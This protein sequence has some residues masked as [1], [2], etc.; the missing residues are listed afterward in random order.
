MKNKRIYKVMKL[1]KA[2]W[3]GNKYTTIDDLGKKWFFTFSTI[4]EAQKI[5]DKYN[6]TYC[7]SDYSN[8][9]ILDYFNSI[10][11][12]PLLD[13]INSLIGL[14]LTYDINI[15]KDSQGIYNYFE[16][17]NKENLVDNFPIL[18]LAWREFKVATF[19]SSILCDEATGKLSLWCTINY[20][21]QHH[22]FGGNGVE[23]LTVWYEEGKWIIKTDKETFNN[24]D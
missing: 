23:I 9:E 16:I 2:D 21:Y 8:D 13:K 5:C 10:D 14:E 11:F 1:K 17:E 24:Q 15:K 18:A 4:E 20:S 12:K 7:L 22:G 3:E 6:H 19:N